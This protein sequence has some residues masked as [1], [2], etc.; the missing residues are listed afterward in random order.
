MSVA[1]LIADLRS[2]LREGLQLLVPSVSGQNIIKMSD[3]LANALDFREAL[4]SYLKFITSNGSERVQ[5][6]V[7]FDANNGFYIAGTSVGSELVKLAAATSVFATL[8]GTGITGGVGTVIKTSVFQ[9]GALIYSNIYIDLTGLQAI[10]TDGD[11]IGDSTNPA[12]LGQF[13]AAR[14]GT[15][16]MGRATCL[17]LPAGASTDINIVTAIEATGKKDDAISGLTGTQ[18]LVDSGGAW[19]NGT[20]KGMLNT[21]IT[22]N[23]YL[24]LTNGAGANAGTYTAG[25]FML[26]FFGY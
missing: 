15:V 21:P 20:V 14:N 6:N 9:F 22:A 18:T 17:E 4:T 12:Y 16:D 19:A 25:K 1:K 23:N 8:A 26:E 7:G 5:T 11:I 3:N 2:A 10:A 24:Y 13:T